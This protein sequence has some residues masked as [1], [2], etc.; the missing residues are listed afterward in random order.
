MAFSVLYAQSSVFP[1]KLKC[2]SW[3]SSRKTILIVGLLPS[4]MGKL[5]AEHYRLRQ[6][7]K[8]KIKLDREC[9]CLNCRVV[10]AGGAGGAPGSENKVS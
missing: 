3:P 4:N 7:C 2:L 1:K 6:M 9:A 5:T 10:K 8:L